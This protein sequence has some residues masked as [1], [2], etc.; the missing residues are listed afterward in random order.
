[1][2]CVRHVQLL[3]RLYRTSFVFRTALGFSLAAG[4]LFITGMLSQAGAFAGFDLAIRDQVAAYQSSLL[5]SFVLFITRFGSTV[6]LF[7]IGSI[8]I[9]ILC[10][11][12][13]WKIIG[14]LLLAMIG[15]AVLHHGFKAVFTISRPEPLLNYAIDDSTSFPSGHAVA[16][17]A[18]YGF[19]A[20]ALVQRMDSKILGA[21]ILTLAALLISLIC[22]SRV[23]I[24]V[25]RASDVIAGLIASA[26]WMVAVIPLSKNSVTDQES[27][28]C[29]QY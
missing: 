14:L 18:F 12:R 24:G 2:A 4:F 7:V 17:T 23:Y 20:M 1:M 5:T 29:E 28:T 22:F 26:I 6:Y 27:T 10:W 25:H 16:S 11:F 13:Q 9:L 19:L 15:Q 8:A 21:I 3:K